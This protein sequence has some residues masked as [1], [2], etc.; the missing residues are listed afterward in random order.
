MASDT[1]NI[2]LYIGAPPASGGQTTKEVMSGI[3]TPVQPDGTVESQVGGNPWHIFETYW[4]PNEIQTGWNK[5]KLFA[6]GAGDKLPLGNPP[7]DTFPTPFDQRHGEGI[8][9]SVAVDGDY[10]VVG[11][12]YAIQKFNYRDG[13]GSKSLDVVA[14]QVWQEGFPPHTE[15]CFG[16]ITITVTGDLQSL[17]K[18]WTSWG[19]DDTERPGQ[20]KFLG[21]WYSFAGDLTA[22][23]ASPPTSWSAYTWYLTSYSGGGAGEEGSATIKAYPCDSDKDCW[24]GTGADAGTCGVS[25]GFTEDEAGTE[26][27]YQETTITGPP[28]AAADLTFYLQAGA[29]YVFKKPRGLVT[30]ATNATP[31]V[32]TLDIFDNNLSLDKI[33]I[34]GVCGNTA[35]NGEFWMKHVSDNDYELYHDRDF[36]NPVSGNGDFKSGGSYKG[37]GTSSW[38]TVGTIPAP[39]PAGWSAANIFDKYTGARAIKST[40]IWDIPL[41]SD[42]R[43]GWSVDIKDGWILIGEPRGNWSVHRSGNWHGNYYAA[44][45]KLY[46]GPRE[47]RPRKE[48]R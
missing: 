10:M 23:G 43:F 38:G 29:V 21:E 36:K 18:G 22:P 41:Y 44:R 27:L 34:Q 42:A 39:F 48:V 26:V 9:F 13:G 3:G 37:A 25:I 11:A 20:F 15:D 16:V 24:V 17:W 46:N 35:A 30:N 28:S 45:D 31:I 32:V 12:P 47:D 33:A 4:E 8:G 5:D 7:F 40:G 6:L 19:A 1:N 2:G 14:E